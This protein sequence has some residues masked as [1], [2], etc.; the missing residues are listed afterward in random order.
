MTHE[1]MQP[2]IMYYCAVHHASFLRHTMPPPSNHNVC[3]PVFLRNK[4][5]TERY[6]SRPVK[7]WTSEMI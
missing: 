1:Y 2:Y 7:M 5:N 4:Y 6:H 3:V